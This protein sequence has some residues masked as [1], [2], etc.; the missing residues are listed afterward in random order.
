MTASN[1][2]TIRD[3]NK[4]TM[5]STLHSYT[6][7]HQQSM[8]VVVFELCEYTIVC[9]GGWG[10]KLLL[11]VRRSFHSNNNLQW[12]LYKYMPINNKVH[13]TFEYIVGCIHIV[14]T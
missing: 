1:L 13:A 3:R 7:T 4:Y 14:Y 11:F 6:A 8:L 5:F 9:M 2:Q 12:F 10:L